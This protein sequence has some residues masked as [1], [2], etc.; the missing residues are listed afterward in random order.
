MKL[1][2]AL[3]VVNETKIHMVIEVTEGHFESKTLDYLKAADRKSFSEA[4]NFAS[5]W[6]E[7]KV[8]FITFNKAKEAIEIDCYM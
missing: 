8:S 7:K 6:S 3:K 2:Q 1:K 4:L 5:K